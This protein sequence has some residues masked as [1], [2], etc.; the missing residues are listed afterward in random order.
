MF[1]LCRCGGLRGGR[2]LTWMSMDR[3][4]LGG[5]SYSPSPLIPLP[6]RERGIW[7]VG[8][9]CSLAL[10]LFVRIRICRIT[11]DL[12]DWDDALHRFHP[13]PSP[14]P[15]RERGFGWLVWLVVAMPCGCCLEASMTGRCRL[16][17]LVGMPAPSPLGCGS[18]PQ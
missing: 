7:L 11:G 17:C 3:Y 15:S 18:S 9:A 8:L 12:Q 16:C 14:L 1:L 6:S 10:W 5:L 13:H 4:G 2:D